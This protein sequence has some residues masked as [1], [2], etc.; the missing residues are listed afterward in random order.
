MQ[1]DQRAFLRERKRE[2]EKERGVRFP[3]VYNGE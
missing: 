3:Y 1:R 2:K